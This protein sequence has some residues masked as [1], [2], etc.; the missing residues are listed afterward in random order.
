MIFAIIGLLA[1][2]PMHSPEGAPLTS[3][4]TPGDYPREALLNAEQG[5]VQFALHIGTDG[6]V[7][8]CRIVQS[9]GSERLDSAT[10]RIMQS[11]ARF[12]PA[13][14]RH[15][16]AVEDTYEGSLTWRIGN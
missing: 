12:K 2:Q 6:L 9:S 3:Y 14:D 11:R 5:V 1:L 7:K 16:N 4:V 10:C 13:R 8:G 15:G